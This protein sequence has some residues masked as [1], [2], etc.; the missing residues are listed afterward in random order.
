MF[1]AK[2]ITIEMFTRTTYLY[3]PA[4]LQFN[5]LFFYP[6]MFIKAQVYFFFATDCCPPRFLSW[7]LLI[8]TRDWMDDPYTDH[9]GPFDQKS[10]PVDFYKIFG[11]FFAC[12]LFIAKNS[13]RT[14]RHGISTKHSYPPRILHS[15]YLSS[16]L[17]DNERIKFTLFL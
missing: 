11:K 14:A 13:F 4:T 15:G 3:A 2:T 5:L 1:T 12:F 17:A 6:K 9:H 7:F 16:I 8:P 10:R